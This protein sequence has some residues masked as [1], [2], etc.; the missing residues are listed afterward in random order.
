MLNTGKANVNTINCVEFT[1][2]LK[3]VPL[4]TYEDADGV[5]IATVDPVSALLLFH[6]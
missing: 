5:K 1:Q 4:S 3:P 6:V 2:P